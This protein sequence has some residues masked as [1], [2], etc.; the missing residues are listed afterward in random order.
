M[1]IFF[2][3]SEVLK[4]IGVGNNEEY[5]KDSETKLFSRI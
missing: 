5:D 2:E 1:M 3:E 4:K